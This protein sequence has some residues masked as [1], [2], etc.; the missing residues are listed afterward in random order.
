[1]AIALTLGIVVLALV[2][3]VGEWFSADITAIGVMA[4]GIVTPEE[5]VSG[6]SNSATM[7]VLALF[8]LSA[9]PG[10][11]RCGG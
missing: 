1:M 7:T 9:G 6:F 5:G 2:C 4:T 10:P 11:G 3:F 8:I